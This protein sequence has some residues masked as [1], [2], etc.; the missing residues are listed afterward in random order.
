[1]YNAE[2]KMDPAAQNQP[3]KSTNKSRI[4]NDAIEK[5]SA[6]HSRQR[7][8][9]SIKRLFFFIAEA[10]KHGWGRDKIV[11]ALKRKGCTF[12]FVAYVELMYDYILVKQGIS[13]RKQ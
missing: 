8:K 12:N 13:K 4:D 6:V 2:A 1:V 3:S 7:W 10:I 11:E 5:E 9:R